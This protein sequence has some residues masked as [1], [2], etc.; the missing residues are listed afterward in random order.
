MAS[1]ISPPQWSSMPNGHPRHLPTSYGVPNVPPSP[2]L[3]NHSSVSVLP[4]TQNVHGWGVSPQNVPPPIHGNNLTAIPPT[5]AHINHIMPPQTPP[6][7]P[8]A[9]FPTQYTSPATTPHVP[10]PVTPNWLHPPPIPASRATTTTPQPFMH[11][12][13]WASNQHSSPHN[14]VPTFPSPLP[15]A[16]PVNH[17][18]QT[19]PFPGATAVYPHPSTPQPSFWGMVPVPTPP[20]TSQTAAVASY[21]SPPPPPP[22][23]ASSHAQLQPNVAFSQY[24]GMTVSAAPLVATPVPPPVAYSV[25]QQNSIAGVHP[26]VSS[27]TQSP[28]KPFPNSSGIEF[29]DPSGS[30]NHNCVGQGSLGGMIVAGPTSAAQLS[31]QPLGAASGVAT[32]PSPADLHPPLAGSLGPQRGLI[33]NPPSQIQGY[34][35]Y[36]RM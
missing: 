29:I 12:N 27:A 15:V 5:G 13:S 33:Y 28:V 1:N 10:S 3:A 18:A 20:P 6:H 26:V 21:A 23:I 14:K 9:G 22:P 17:T 32:I 25:Y 2:G 4:P 31:Q 34:H 16:S 7:P 11:P 8:P 35:P 19:T 36:R 30:L 24:G